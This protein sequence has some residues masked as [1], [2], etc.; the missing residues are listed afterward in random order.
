MSWYR[1][2]AWGRCS[3]GQGHMGTGLYQG[4][5]LPSLLEY[6][7]A[8]LHVLGH[9]HRQGLLH[10]ALLPDHILVQPLAMPSCLLSDFLY[11]TYSYILNATGAHMVLR[12][13]VCSL[14]QSHSLNAFPN[15]MLSHI[16]TLPCL[17]GSPFTGCLQ[18]CSYGC[19]LA[20]TSDITTANALRIVHQ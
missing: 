15:C 3:A 17:A 13:G 4:P 6:G 9:V 11:S 20:P 10:R 16:F 1:Q 8:V 2:E 19:N 5:S 7:K 18:S 14:S 12:F